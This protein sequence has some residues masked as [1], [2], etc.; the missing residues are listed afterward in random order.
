MLN[1]IFFIMFFML[2]GIAWQPEAYCTDYTNYFAIPLKKLQL[3]LNIL[4]EKLTHLQD[5]L[6]K[7]KDKLSV[8]KASSSG[9]NSDGNNDRRNLSIQK[10]Q[11]QLTAASNLGNSNSSDTKRAQ[12]SQNKL[13]PLFKKRKA[14]FDDLIEEYESLSRRDDKETQVNEAFSYFDHLFKNKSFSI[15]NDALSHLNIIKEIATQ[16]LRR[17]SKVRNFLQKTLPETKLKTYLDN[18][19]NRENFKKNLKR[20]QDTTS[21]NKNSKRDE[22]LEKA[23]EFEEINKEIAQKSI[24]TVERR[25]QRY[26]NL[27]EVLNNLLYKINLDLTNNVKQIEDN[28]RTSAKNEINKI[29]DV[30]GSSAS[31]YIEKIDNARTIEDFYNSINEIKEKILPFLNDQLQIAEKESNNI[32]KASTEP[33]SFDEEEITSEQLENHINNLLIKALDEQEINF[34]IV[35]RHLKLLKEIE[36]A[37]P[38]P[39]IVVS[40]RGPQPTKSAIK[41]GASLKTKKEVKHKESAEFRNVIFDTNEKTERVNTEIINVN[42]GPKEKLRPKPRPFFFGLK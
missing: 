17:D 16:I 31:A 2:A 18:N 36:P 12:Q 6:S 23:K 37:D 1:N 24:E 5:K 40:N 8:S 7:L 38:V 35:N 13:T 11:T 29:L 4:K 27:N 28:E 9:S 34:D 15:N 19:E 41:E 32:K 25:T 20:L 26:N 33:H 42:F 3:N 14:L 21:K 10:S 30:F 39:K 22:V